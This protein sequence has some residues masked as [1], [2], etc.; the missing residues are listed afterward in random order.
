[1][2]PI[3]KDQHFSILSEPQVLPTGG[4]HS[5]FPRMSRSA[6]PLGMITYAH[7]GDRFWTRVIYD[8]ILNNQHTDEFDLRR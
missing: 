4:H 2:V 5:G 3:Q 8:L 7:L 6:N 1:M